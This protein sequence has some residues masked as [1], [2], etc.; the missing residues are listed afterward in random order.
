MLA[1]KGRRLFSEI[2]KTSL[3]F[4][5]YVPRRE[6]KDKQLGTTLKDGSDSM[7]KVFGED[8]KTP[9][10]KYDLHV[11]RAEVGDNKTS[12]DRHHEK[13]K[14]KDSKKIIGFLTFTA[15]ALAYYTYKDHKRNIANGER[16]IA[17]RIEMFNKRKAAAEHRD[18]I[19]QQK[20]LEARKE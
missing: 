20:L 11:P 4:G 3:K 7:K 6:E 16:Q 15:F 1:W 19:Y 12:Y 14:Y 17:E 2:N 9:H 5:Q 10:E 13:T 18:K 8:Y